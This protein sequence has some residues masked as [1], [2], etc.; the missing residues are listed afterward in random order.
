ML[1]H[2][3]VHDM[4]YRMYAAWLLFFSSHFLNKK[5]NKKTATHLLNN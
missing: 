2:N 1:Q 5:Q 4:F 3:T